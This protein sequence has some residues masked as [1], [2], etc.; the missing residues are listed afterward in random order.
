M[1]PLFSDRL[2]LMAVIQPEDLLGLLR[3]EPAWVHR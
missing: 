2:A 3:A 1:W